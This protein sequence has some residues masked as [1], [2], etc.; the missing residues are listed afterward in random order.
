LLNGHDLIKLGAEL[1]KEPN[2]VKIAPSLRLLRKYLNYSRYPFNPSV[3]TK[4]FCDECL[5]IVMLVKD[6]V[7]LITSR[8]PLETKLNDKFNKNKAARED[9]FER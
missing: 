9:D 3:Y 6:N 5:E 2:Y 7:D 1:S 4:Q 8:K